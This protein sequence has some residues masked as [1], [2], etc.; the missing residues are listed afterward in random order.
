MT[1]IKPLFEGLW[2]LGGGVLVNSRGPASDLRVRV[3][4][5][6]SCDIQKE[7]RTSRIPR[8]RAALPPFPPSS[9]PSAL[10]QA[11]HLLLWTVDF[12]PCLCAR[13]QGSLKAQPSSSLRSPSLPSLVS[14]TGLPH[15]SPSPGALLVLTLLHLF[16]GRPPVTL[17]PSV[18]WPCCSCLLPWPSC[19]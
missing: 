7:F 1:K 4:Q 9:A 3:G 10:S 6:Q 5:P 17:R 2:S 16:G 12:Q 8:K 18:T 14:E 19:G 11:G 15:L 13:C